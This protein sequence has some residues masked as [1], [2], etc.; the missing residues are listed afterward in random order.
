MLKHSIPA[1]A[2]ITA[3]AL[4]GCG[5]QQTRTIVQV[6]TRTVTVTQAATANETPTHTVT[7]PRPTLP[8]AQQLQRAGEDG[9]IMTR[10]FGAALRRAI[11]PHYQI[12]SSVYNPTALQCSASFTLGIYQC[13]SSDM[14]GD[15]A[16]YNIVAK[17]GR[18]TA[19]VDPSRSYGAGHFQSTNYSLPSAYPR[20]LSGTY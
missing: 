12:S 8:S 6:Q 18:W 14:E 15:Q 7:T 1:I 5:S 4:A 20:T 13:Q 17:D 3:V 2:G 19:N 16:V 11:G 9:E 10:L